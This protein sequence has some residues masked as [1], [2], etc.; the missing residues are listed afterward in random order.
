MWTM[1]WTVAHRA[2]PTGPS[3]PPRGPRMRAALEP[4]ADVAPSRP[5]EDGLRAV[6][7]AVVNVAAAQVHLEET[8]RARERGRSWGRILTFLSSGGWN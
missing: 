4:Y 3:W 2:H 7:E 6:A 8:V 1:P 5:D